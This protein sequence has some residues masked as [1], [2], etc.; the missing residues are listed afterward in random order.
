MKYIVAGLFLF[1]MGFVSSIDVHAQTQDPEFDLAVTWMYNNG[2]TQYDSSEEFRPN[3]WL[4]RQEAAKFFVAYQQAMNP[5]MPIPEIGC[6]FSD[7][8]VF[9]TTLASYIFLSCQM[10]LFK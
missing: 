10:S 8:N 1:V 2:L 6:V 3:D 9:D 7:D 4:T 5:D